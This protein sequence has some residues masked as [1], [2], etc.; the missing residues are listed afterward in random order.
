M[1][2][3]AEGAYKCP[4][5][6]CFEVAKDFSKPWGVAVERRASGKVYVAD[7]ENDMLYEVDPANGQKRAV[8]TEKR[9]LRNVDVAG[10]NLAYATTTYDDKVIEINLTNGADHHRHLRDHRPG[11][12]GRHRRRNH[13]VRDVPLPA[14]SC[15]R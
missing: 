5:R 2:E 8:L 9:D 13:R 11:G 6:A 4:A 3:A 1:A 10:P 12:G 15:T 14:T 7:Q